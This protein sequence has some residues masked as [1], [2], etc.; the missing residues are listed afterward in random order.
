MDSN[1]LR[2]IE[3]DLVVERGCDRVD[4]IEKSCEQFDLGAK[5]KRNSL[6]IVEDK[7]LMMDD[8]NNIHRLSLQVES[9]DS[10]SLVMTN[11]AV[12]R[13]IIRIG[14]NAG[15]VDFGE[16]NS[17]EINNCD[18]PTEAINQEVQEN[19]N[20]DGDDEVD[21]EVKD[22]AIVN[23]LGQINEIVGY[24]LC[25]NLWD[26]FRYVVTVIRNFCVCTL[27]HVSFFTN[28]SVCYQFKTCGDI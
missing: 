18:T 15:G 4:N 21:N 20:D 19:S 2:I 28:H 9:G 10:D 13:T 14:S 8:N 11:E 16:L 27:S 6:Q 23:I 5:E 12:N 1:P 3:D 24:F 17:S 7:D 26:I 25:L 22:E